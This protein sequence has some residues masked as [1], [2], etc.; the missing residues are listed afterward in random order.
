MKE[1]SAKID[2]VQYANTVDFY[3]SFLKD[4]SGVDRSENK[5]E[6]FPNDYQKKENDG[7]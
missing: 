7:R 5:K 1:K 6:D 3:E 2:C 4:R